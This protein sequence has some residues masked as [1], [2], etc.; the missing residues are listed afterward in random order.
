MT[1]SAN[2]T[3]RCHINSKDGKVFCCTC[4]L[5]SSGEEISFID[6][7]LKLWQIQTRKVIKDGTTGTRW[8][9]VVKLTVARTSTSEQETFLMTESAV[10]GSQFIRKYL[11]VVPLQQNTSPSLFTI[12]TVQ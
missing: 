12:N 11:Y 2:M 3:L 10:Q 9:A 7:P 8:I 4:I 6:F 5:K 1:K